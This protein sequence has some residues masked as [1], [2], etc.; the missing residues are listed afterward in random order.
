VGSACVCLPRGTISSSRPNLLPEEKTPWCSPP[1]TGIHFAQIINPQSVLTEILCL[2][3][4]FLKLSPDPTE[5]QHNQMPLEKLT[6]GLEV[7]TVP[8]LRDLLDDV[9]PNP[10]VGSR[11]PAPHLPLP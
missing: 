5:S 9:S 2:Q 8:N 3:P 1:V 4:S 10:L 6:A 7:S 11:E